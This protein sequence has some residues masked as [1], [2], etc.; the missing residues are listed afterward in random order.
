M[1]ETDRQ[2]RWL[3]LGEDNLNSIVRDRL[4]HLVGQ[5]ARDAEARGRSVDRRF[6]SVD[7]EAGAHGHAQFTLRLGVAEDPMLRRRERIKRYRGERR[8]VFWTFRR[9][10]R[11]EL[12]GT[13]ANDAAHRADP[14]PNRRAIGK[15]ADAHGNVDVIVDQVQVAVGEH[16][17]DVDLRP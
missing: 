7:G 1:D 2:G 11:G 3:V 4:C 15:R 14:R 12:G 5:D 10:V 13:T 16:K 8:Q 6:R 17:P 9:A